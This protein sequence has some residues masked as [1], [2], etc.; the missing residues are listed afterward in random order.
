[1]I[2]GIPITRY[3]EEMQLSIRRRLTLFRQ[4]L[5][6]VHYAHVNLVAHRTSNRPISW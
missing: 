6:A 1:M 3:C 2:D 4:V 5:E